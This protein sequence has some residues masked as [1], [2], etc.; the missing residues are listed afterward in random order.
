[1]TRAVASMVELVVRCCDADEVLLF[2]SYAKG[3]QRVDSDVDLLVLCDHPRPE[4][5]KYEISDLLVRFPVS[6]DV[7]VMSRSSVPSAWD[8]RGGFLHSILSSAIAAYV[9]SEHSVLEELS[10]P[11]DV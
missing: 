8:D 9:H 1:M 5:L 2:G 10:R 4:A 7:H 11:L 3:M 6:V